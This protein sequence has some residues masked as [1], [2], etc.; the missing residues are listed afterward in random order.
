MRTGLVIGKFMPL[1]KGHL[2]L[3][4]FALEHCDSLVVLVSASYDEP[5]TGTQRLN[6]LK[7]IYKDNNKVNPW[8]LN[9]DEA[10]L[11]NTTQSL[12]GVSRLWANYL[13]EHLPP[14]DVI[15]ASEAYGAYI[16]RF[17]GCEQIIFDE[18]RKVVPVSSK[19]LLD[20]PTVYATYLPDVVKDYFIQK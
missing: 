18:P 14:I 20:N 11:S 15:F 13:I 6:W 10:V 1:H 5:I 12:D 4:D 17:L 8:L 16:A 3:I 19:Q 7:E 2:A 9:Y